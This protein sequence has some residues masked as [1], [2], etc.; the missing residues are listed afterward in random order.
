MRYAGL[1]V[2]ALAS[3][4]AVDAAEDEGCNRPGGP[5]TTVAP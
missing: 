4:V 2:L 3:C 1:L 5:I